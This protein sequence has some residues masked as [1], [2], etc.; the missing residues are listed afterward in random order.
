[1]LIHFD[2]VTLPLELYTKEI[3]G[4]VDKVFKCEALQQ[5]VAYDS[6]NLEA[7]PEFSSERGRAK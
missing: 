5:G 3:N 7:L 1:M 6:K 2:L 4:N